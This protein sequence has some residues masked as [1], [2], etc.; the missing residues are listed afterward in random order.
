MSGCSE[1]PRK[2]GLTRGQWMNRVTPHL[3]YL[4]PTIQEAWGS[5]HVPDCENVWKNLP[6]VRS[7]DSH[8]SWLI[9]YTFPFSEV[10]TAGQ[11]LAIRL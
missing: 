6:L 10:G 8:P 9:N 2:A 1:R 5:A 3:W 4:I 7:E 11:A